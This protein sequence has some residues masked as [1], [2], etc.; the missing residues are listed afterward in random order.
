M[1]IHVI[2]RNRHVFRV[3]GKFSDW[4]TRR[5]SQFR[6]VVYSRDIARCRYFR[7]CRNDRYVQLKRFKRISIASILHQTSRARRNADERCRWRIAA[8][9]RDRINWN[10]CFPSGELNAGQIKERVRANA[11]ARKHTGRPGNNDGEFTRFYRLHF[12]QARFHYSLSTGR[13]FDRCRLAKIRKIRQIMP[14]N[15]I[16]YGVKVNVIYSIKR[17]L[18]GDTTFIFI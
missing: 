4:A 5:R 11:C 14:A 15:N 18:A 10:N 12:F 3:N 16:E 13:P 1:R 17:A 7:L 2:W 9:H 6:R 8:P